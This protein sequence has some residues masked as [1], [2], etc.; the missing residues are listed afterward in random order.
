MPQHKVSPLQIDFP[1]ELLERNA[2]QLAKAM[3][4]II[5]RT[6]REKHVMELKRV[7]SNFVALGDWRLTLE[8]TRQ[9]DPDEEMCYEEF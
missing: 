1:I 2:H 3:I 4:S 6:G 9:P 7:S 8:R 5:I